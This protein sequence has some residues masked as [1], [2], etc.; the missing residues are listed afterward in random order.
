M[1]G[2]SGTATPN[3]MPIEGYALAASEGLGLQVAMPVSGSFEGISIYAQTAPGTGTSRTYTLRKG[4]VDTALTVSVSDTN[5]TNS[6][7]ASVSFV[8]G[9]LFNIGFTASGSPASSLV[10]GCLKLVMATDGESILANT[11][12]STLSS[13][14]TVYGA[15]SGRTSQT[16][17]TESDSYGIAPAAFTWKTL[18]ATLSAAPGSGKN[19]A[20][21][22]RLGGAS[23]TLVATVADS[24]TTNVDT[25]HTV[26]V[27]AGDLL[28]YM[29]VPTGTPASALV[30]VSSVA[31]IAPAGGG[32]PL[33]G[34]G[35]LLGVGS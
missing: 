33:A 6:A 13:S 17:S 16:E 34:F 22:A 10:R 23:Q 19:R 5:K 35:L 14:A 1:W 21:T 26:S 30:S 12:P 28:N 2:H 29:E 4:G 20:V 8:A 15:V 24:A 31:Y 32:N 11:W 27:V 18:R 7:S 9:D 25:T 3:Y